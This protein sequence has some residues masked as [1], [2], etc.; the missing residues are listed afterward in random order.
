MPDLLDQLSDQLTF[1]SVAAAIKEKYGLSSSGE[2]RLEML[3]L[4]ERWANMFERY[5]KRPDAKPE[6]LQQ[7]AADLK[8]MRRAYGHIAGSYIEDNLMVDYKIEAEM[9]R[10][11]ASMYRQELEEMKTIFQMKNLAPDRLKMYELWAEKATHF[12]AFD[13]LR[14]RILKGEKL[15]DEG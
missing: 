12:D 3:N 7:N 10:T 14:K 11:L 15:Q 9:Y 2:L 4:I 6:M 1:D 8:T 13:A 5:T